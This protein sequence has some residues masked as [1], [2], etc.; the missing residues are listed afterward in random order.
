MIYLAQH[1]STGVEIVVHLWPIAAEVLGGF[2][3]W[4]ATCSK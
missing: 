1:S 3:G 4:V 2:N